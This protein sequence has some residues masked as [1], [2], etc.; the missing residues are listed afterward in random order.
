M[1]ITL[2]KQT[3][4]K[5]KKIIDLAKNPGE[6]NSFKDDVEEKIGKPIQEMIEDYMMSPGN[7]NE[8]LI[9]QSLLELT[10]AELADVL[11]VY[12]FFAKLIYDS[13]IVSDDE[14]QAFWKLCLANAGS[15]IGRIGSLKLIE[16]L[17]TRKNLG[18][19]LSA[20]VLNVK[21]S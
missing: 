20:A 11:A 1:P 18:A 10:N 2:D 7:E 17:K 16:Y 15:D 13:S 4:K 3:L 8:D 12:Y 21:Y 5:I 6:E 19:V 9:E 14:M